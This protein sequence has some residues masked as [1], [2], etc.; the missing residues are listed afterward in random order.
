MADKTSGAMDAIKRGW[1]VFPIK[2]GSSAP[3]LIKDW[4]AN[5]SCDLDQ[6]FD[7]SL[8][9]PNCN[10]GLACGPSGLFVL[11]IDQK[12]EKNGRLELDLLEL[13]YGEV[14]DTYRVR[15]PSGGWHYCYYGEGA[16]SVD[17]IGKGLDSKSVGGYVVLPGSETDKGTYVAEVPAVIADC[18]AWLIE[19]AGMAIAREPR[20]EV[21]AG[22]ELDRP[23]AI[24]RAVKYLLTAEP[25]IEGQGGDNNAI[26]VALRTRDYGLSE[27]ETLRLMHEFWNDRCLPP[28]EFEELERKVSNAYQYALLPA[29]NCSPEADFGVLPSIDDNSGVIVT[30]GRDYKPEELK[31]REWVIEGRYLKGMPTLTYAP[32]GVG[33]SSYT[34][35]ELVS[36][37]SGRA[38][39]GEKIIQ[40]GKVWVISTE[41]SLDELRK[42][43][44]TIMLAFDLDD[45]VRDN[46]ALTS[47]SDSNVYL[48][49]RKD[50]TARIVKRNMDIFINLIKENNFLVTCVDPLVKL[51]RNCDE[52]SNSDMD[53]LA[54]AIRTITTET[55]SVLG[56]CHHTRKMSGGQNGAESDSARG[57]SALRDACRI[58]HTLVPMTKQEARILNVPDNEYGDY[59]KRVDAKNN[60]VPKDNK[61][62]WF[63][64]MSQIIQN[65]ESIGYVRPWV[66]GTAENFKYLEDIVTIYC[67][68]IRTLEIAKVLRSDCQWNYSN[69]AHAKEGLERLL[70]KPQIYEGKKIFIERRQYRG[71]KQN[72]VLIEDYSEGYGYTE[73]Q[74]D[75]RGQEKRK[76][77]KDSGS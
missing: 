4:E 17:K 33:K 60:L 71:S 9:F 38:L 55:D 1:R 21:A 64:K 3:P 63:R 48:V 69:D 75:R 68:P 22:V 31:P 36:V 77:I 41:D 74:G 54:Q 50:K 35:L 14:P 28:W 49:E 46:V 72:F 45:S 16:S 34:M 40:Q 8:D 10:W 39:S 52:N 59:F 65:G 24:T 6:V 18:P 42:H 7:W 12:N 62:K 66:F 47:I 27:F 57:A 32:G 20:E 58:V 56:T 51:H 30:W 2:H 29:G 5:A 70:K 61:V 73:I 23:E 67:E 53:L 37:A 15:T 76:H 19:K 43:F 44:E 13:E 25:S 26:R 11:D